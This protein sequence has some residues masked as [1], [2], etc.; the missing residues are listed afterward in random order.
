MTKFIRGWKNTYDNNDNSSL[1]ISLV[2]NHPVE[3]GLFLFLVNEYRNNSLCNCPKEMLWFLDYF[4]E[5]TIFDMTFFYTY[6]IWILEFTS[7]IQHSTNVRIREVDRPFSVDTY[8]V[9]KVVEPSSTWDRCTSAIPVCLVVCGGDVCVRRLR[10]DVYFFVCPTIRY[11]MRGFTNT[12]LG[13]YVY[14]RL[15]C[16]N[17]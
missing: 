12:Y 1:I 5:D 13:K 17:D 3:L 10:D 2:F 4:K 14:T 15:V 8:R 11:P 16:N 6:V 9:I 7:F